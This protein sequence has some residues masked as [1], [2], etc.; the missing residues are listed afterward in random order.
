MLVVATLPCRLST[1]YA[2]FQKAVIIT[3]EY[4][5]NLIIDMQIYVFLVITNKWEKLNYDCLLQLHVQVS[6][7]VHI[8][9]SVCI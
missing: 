8:T 3:S 1:S 6:K 5:F 7:A 9:G 2:I 4:Y